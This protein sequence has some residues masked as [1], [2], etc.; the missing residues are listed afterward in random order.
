MSVGVID[1]ELRIRLE[2]DAED[3]DA[4]AFVDELPDLIQMAKLHA[5]AIQ[6]DKIFIENIEVKDNTTYDGV[7]VA[8]LSHPDQNGQ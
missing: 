3:E 1:V 8:A 5:P 2:C 6:D 4:K 7:P